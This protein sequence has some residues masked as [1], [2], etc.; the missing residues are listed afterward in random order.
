[1]NFLAYLRTVEECLRDCLLVF[2]ALCASTYLD[3]YSSCRRILDVIVEPEQVSAYASLFDTCGNAD[4]LCQPA[5]G[6]AFGFVETGF[7]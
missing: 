5:F 3:F 1:M 4:P 2:A 7:P 6:F